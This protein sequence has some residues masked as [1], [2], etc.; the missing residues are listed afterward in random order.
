M[1]NFANCCVSWFL[2]LPLGIITYIGMEML[3]HVIEV[4]VAYS[5]SLLTPE[6]RY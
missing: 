2:Y 6:Y 4:H 1:I 5:S 3:Y